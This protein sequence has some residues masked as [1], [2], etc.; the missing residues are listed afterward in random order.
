MS[1]P[2]RIPLPD[3]RRF[4]EEEMVRRADE[5]LAEMRLRRSVRDFSTRP[6]PRRII[7]DCVAA[8][9][10]APSGAN[11]QP[12]HFVVVESPEVKRRIR[13]AAEEAERAFYAGVA[14]P[15]WL[16][17]LAPLGTGPE[18]PFLETAPYLIAVFVETS[19]RTPDGTMLKN[20]YPGPSVGIAV[21][22]LIAGLHRAGLACLPY[23]PTRMSFLNEMLGRPGNERPMLIVVAGYPAEHADVPAIGRK[24]LGGVM[25]VL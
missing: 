9:A 1:G 3:D 6:V 22:M 7:E 23:T 18:K 12:W 25:T 24:P 20:Y 11:L 16:A 13:E 10:T 14:P 15:Q 5:Y 17:D 19:R 8:A 4:S 2:P 21:G